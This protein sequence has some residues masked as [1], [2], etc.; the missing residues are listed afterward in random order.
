MSMM[1]ATVRTMPE[2]TKLKWLAQFDLKSRLAVPNGVERLRAKSKGGSFETF[3]EN[4][5]GDDH[6]LLLTVIFESTESDEAIEAM[7]EMAE[8]AIQLLTFVTRMPFKNVK[9]RALIDWSPGMEERRVYLFFKEPEHKVVGELPQDI[10][11]STA[12]FHDSNL[13]EQCRRAL[14]WYTVG[15]RAAAMEDQFQY[16]WFAIELSASGYKAEKVID[17]CSKCRT[18]L[19]C[20]S[21]DGP[22]QHR[23]YPSQKINS[24]LASVGVPSKI[25]EHL[26]SFRHHLMHGANRQVLEELAERFGAPGG[27]AD[28]VDAAGEAA[29]R[30]VNSHV[31]LESHAP[32]EVQTG[33]ADTYITKRIISSLE[34]FVKFAGDPENPTLDDI[35]LPNVESSFIERNPDGTETTISMIGPT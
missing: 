15:T 14:H 30:A 28:V 24:F 29:W 17:V 13:T 31:S 35:K 12:I 20:P 8:H 26:A 5:P 16:F 33:S 27:L 18:E 21:C 34:M 11:E 7:D 19:Y 32:Q 22:S 1:H 3:L 2:S 10:Y 23:P 4:K 9:K 25:I 6:N